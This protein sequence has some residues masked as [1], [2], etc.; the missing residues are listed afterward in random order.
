MP[1]S[2]IRIT[3]PAWVERFVA[4]QEPCVSAEARMALAIGLA[5]ANVEGGTG[6]PFG[7]AVFDLVTHRPVAVGVNLVQSAQNAVLHAE[8]VALML[9]QAT[10]GRYTLNAPGLNPHALVTSCEPCAMCLGALLWSGVRELECGATRADA[11]RIGFDEGPVFA[12]SYAYLAARGVGV[13]LEVRRAAAAAVLEDYRQ[14]DGTI[15]NG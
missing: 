12:A 9:A 8:I 4:W 5:R 15:Y 14:S 1:L 13:R 2:E 10:L 11:A 3:L 6:G 7:A